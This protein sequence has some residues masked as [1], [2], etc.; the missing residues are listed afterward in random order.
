MICHNLHLHLIPKT[1]IIYHFQLEFITESN[2]G[3]VLE[4]ILCC[5]I[6]IGSK[7]HYFEV[8]DFFPKIL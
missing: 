4:L 3:L 7:L 8:P 2:R 1:I 6:S 5:F